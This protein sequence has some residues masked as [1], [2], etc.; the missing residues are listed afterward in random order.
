MTLEVWDKFISELVGTRAG[1]HYREMFAPTVIGYY[2]SNAPDLLTQVYC[3]LSVCAV[4]GYYL[5]HLDPL[6]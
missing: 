5:P 3:D 2:L 6:Y 1:K 4:L